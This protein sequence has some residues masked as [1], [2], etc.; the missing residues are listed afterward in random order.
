MNTFARA[1][2]ILL[3]LLAAAIAG[4][5]AGFFLILG[6]GYATGADDRE[7]ALAMGVATTGMPLG[8]IAGI[9]LAL[10]GV[11]RWYNRPEGEP[12]IGTKGLIGVIGVPLVLT[13][14]LMLRIWWITTPELPSPKPRLLVQV[15]APIALRDDTVFHQFWP[16]YHRAGTHVGAYTIPDTTETEGTLTLDTDFYMIYRVEDRRITVPYADKAHAGFTLTIGERPTIMDAYSDWQDPDFFLT[17]NIWEARPTDVTDPP[18][19]QIRYKVVGS[20]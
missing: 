16:S 20:R 8:A 3:L 19:I 2:I 18:A 13:G 4:A 10:L 12:F 15:R 7:G 14:L 5:F 17:D 6:L 9:V 1:L 11:A